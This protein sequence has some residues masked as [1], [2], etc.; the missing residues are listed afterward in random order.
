[1]NEERAQVNGIEITYETIGDPS[2]PALLL[3]M[4]LGTQL[5]HWDRELCELLAARG[6]RVIRFDNRDSGTS[7]QIDAPVPNL[8][9]GMA[10]LRID[11]PYLLED[12]AD[13]GFGLLDHLEIPAAHVVGASMGGMIAQEMAIRRPERVLSLTSIMST[14]GERRAGRPKLR[15]WSVLTRRAP[16]ERDAYVEHFVRVFR[17]IG[18]KGF[19]PDEDRVR[20]LAGAAYERG[21]HPAGTGRQLAAIM[22]S[23]DRTRRR[24]DR[25]RHPRREADRHRGDGSRPAARGVARG[26]RGGGRDGRPPSGA[27]A[28]LAPHGR[29][30]L[31]R[32]LAGEAERV[33][34][35]RAGHELIEGA[36]LGH[37]RVAGLLPAGSRGLVLDRSD[38]RRIPTEPERGVDGLQHPAH[39]LGA[40]DH[41]H[42]ARVRAARHHALAD[43]RELSPAAGVH[44]PAPRAVLARHLAHPRVQAEARERPAHQRRLG[45]EAVVYA[46][47]GIDGGSGVGHL[48][49]ALVEYRRAPSG[50][51]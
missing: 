24:G 44:A 26:R 22:A 3:V 37:Q 4:G 25:A 33:F 2:D 32:Q 1:M 49:R 47:A 8:V 29:A 19:A 40:L 6:F 45:L 38:R 34:V 21:H 18:S 31:A 5:I 12:M 17:M 7:T 20:E 11:A 35:E 16:E 28:G 10:G 39:P 27:G 9:R 43:P 36:V 48:Q 42:D 41:E 30:V 13:D 51:P 15:V 50:Q 46:R 14:T 23:G